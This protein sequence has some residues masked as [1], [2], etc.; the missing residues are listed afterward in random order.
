VSLQPA[1]AGMAR[2]EASTS[3]PMP[4]GATVGSTEAAPTPS[5][6]AAEILEEA[7]AGARPAE[8]PRLANTRALGSEAAPVARMQ[9]RAADDVLGL[10]EIGKATLRWIKG[11][12][13]WLR[14][15][16]DEQTTGN[17]AMLDSAD[18]SASP[19]DG[20]GAGRNTQV[21]SAILP[22][23]GRDAALDP[24]TAIGYG[25]APLPSSVDPNLNLMQKVISVVREVLE[26]PM[27]W[28]VVSLIVIGAVLVK[29]FDR[30][31]TK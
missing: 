22:R 3:S 13:P 28:L 12:V 31:P 21:G 6:L 26:H 4:G 2:G 15:D 27:T 14:S 17:A 30:R 9:P 19:L 10:R 1:A 25:N 8:S 5:A 24:S 7:E 18:W 23:T 11:T 20:G 29:K 16:T